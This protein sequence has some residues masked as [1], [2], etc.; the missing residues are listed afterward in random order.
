MELGIA[1]RRALVAGSSSGIGASIAVALAAEGARV[2]IHGR[3]KGS[4]P[5]RSPR[6]SAR[7][8]ARPP[9][10]TATWG[11]RRQSTPSVMAPWRHLAA[12]T[13]W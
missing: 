9:S 6:P 5:N 12:S 8:P 13:S 1:G 4:V 2:V 11:T 3:D 10:S 7:R